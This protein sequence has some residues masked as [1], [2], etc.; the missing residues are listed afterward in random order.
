[1][2]GYDSKLL[3]EAPE[4]SQVQKQD[5]YDVRILGGA[6]VGSAS[7]VHIGL[8]S[9]SNHD[10]PGVNRQDKDGYTS[11]YSQFADATRKTPFW[12]TRRGMI[13][14]ALLALLVVGAAVGGGVGGALGSKNHKSTSPS[15]GSDQGGSDGS[16]GQGGSDTNQGTSPQSSS[17]QAGI[18]TSSTIR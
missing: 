18:A 11:P 10:A 12:R 6:D 14:L 13:I 4:T 9:T 3:A 1:M 8:R 15:S 5:G 7:A 16:G 17:A 2:E